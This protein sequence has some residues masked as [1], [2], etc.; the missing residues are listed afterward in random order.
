MAATI[1]SDTI[2][3]ISSI[4]DDDRMSATGAIIIDNGSTMMKCGWSSDSSPRAVFPTVV[5]VPRHG[6]IMGGCRTHFVGDEALHKHSQLALSYPIRH[7]IIEDGQWDNMEKVWPHTFYNELRVAPEE[8]PLI[9]TEPATNPHHIRERTTMMMFE[10]FGIPAYY[11]IAQPVLSLLASGRTTGLVMENGG[12]ATYAVPVYEG[13]V[14]SHAVTKANYGGNDI[15]E[16]IAKSLGYTSSAEREVARDIKEKL[17]YISLNYDSDMKECKSAKS[18][19][20]KQ[21]ELPGN[22][23]ETP[24]LY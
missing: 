24:L 16:A 15:T 14:I 21:Y 8:Q 6:T 13:H 11:L 22:R 7:G 10:T 2:A 23:T 19:L 18:P 3:S 20:M 12:D 9:M 5:G 17:G 4:P 1:A